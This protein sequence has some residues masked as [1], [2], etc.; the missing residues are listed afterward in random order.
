MNET[1]TL[2][3]LAAQIEVPAN[4]RTTNQRDRHLMQVAELL[5]QA[6]SKRACDL[7]VLPELSSV[8]Y[9]QHCFEHSDVFAEDQHGPSFKILSKLAKKYAVAILYGAPRLDEQGKLFVSQFLIDDKGASAGVFDKLHIAQF[10]ASMEKNYFT[11]GNKLLV[12]DIK[13][14]RFAPLICYDIRFA[15]VADELARRHKVDVVLHPVAFYQD[16][17]FYSWRSF[18]IT[19]A[20]ENQIYWLS[21]NRAGEKF[22]RSILC[23]PWVDDDTPETVLGA[24]QALAY[25]EVDKQSITQV[26]KRYPFQQ[27]KRDDYAVL[28]K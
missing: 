27:D 9:S 10:G 12:F 15:A 1:Q 22:G 19:R 14:L 5:E 3:I 26:R 28:A 6:L 18:V 2:T 17:S 20:L 11:S 24:P 4:M 23:P 25:F 21:V 7:V 13:G 16:Q 8:S